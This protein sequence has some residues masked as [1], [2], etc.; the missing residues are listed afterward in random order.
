MNE[1][2]Y[3]LCHPFMVGARGL[4]GSRISRRPHAPFRHDAERLPVRVLPSDGL[5]LVR[6]SQP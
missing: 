1:S 6:Y 2:T 3:A 5:L 4:L